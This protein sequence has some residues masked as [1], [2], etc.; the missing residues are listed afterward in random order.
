MNNHFHNVDFKIKCVISELNTFCPESAGS[1]ENMTV[2]QIDSY[3]ANLKEAKES[4]ISAINE[5]APLLTK[6][7]NCLSPWQWLK[8]KPQEAGHYMWKENGAPHYTARF[9]KITD[10][11]DGLEVKFPEINSTVRLHKIADREWIKIPN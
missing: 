6:E 2:E 3:I 10:N 9:C 7:Y 1:V 5:R 8:T 4:L 11:G